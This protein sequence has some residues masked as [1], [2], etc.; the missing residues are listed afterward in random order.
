MPWVGELYDNEQ[1]T[2]KT[3][4]LIFTRI[5]GFYLFKL[6]QF[7]IKYLLIMIPWYN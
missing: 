1:T 2:M 7:K 5:K 3:I 4:S 6:D